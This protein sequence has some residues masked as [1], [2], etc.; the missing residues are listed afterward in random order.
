MAGLGS[1]ARKLFGSANDRRLKGYEPTVAAVNAL[2]PEGAALT[3][4]ELRAR[5]EKFRAEIKDGKGQPAL[6]R[7]TF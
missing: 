7:G 5:T 4:E 3:D 2:E 1:V 6:S